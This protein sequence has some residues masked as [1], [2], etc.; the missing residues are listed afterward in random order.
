M[1][2]AF[3]S[4]AVLVALRPGNRRGAVRDAAGPKPLKPIVNIGD[5]RD[6]AA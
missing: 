5:L 1:N 4:V 3:S 2:P 6:D